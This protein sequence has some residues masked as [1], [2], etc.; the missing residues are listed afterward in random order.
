MLLCDYVLKFEGHEL[1][2]SM[3]EPGA[4]CEHHGGAYAFG[5]PFADLAF[6]L[7]LPGHTAEIFT[8]EGRPLARLHVEHVDAELS[9][10]SGDLT[11]ETSDARA[12]GLLR[13][14]LRSIARHW[15]V[16]HFAPRRAPRRN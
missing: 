2:L 11:P 5:L 13:G 7:R 3:P 1:A 4:A 15:T 14:W 9:L 6:A 12:P 8:P 10:L 16:T